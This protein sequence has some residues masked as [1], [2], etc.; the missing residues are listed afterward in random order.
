MT[1]ELGSEEAELLRTLLLAEVEGKRV[2][3]HHARNIDY[4]TELQKQER[5]IQDI[6]KQLGS[7]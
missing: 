6:L 2:E 5:L 7:P 1:I 3:L 4:K